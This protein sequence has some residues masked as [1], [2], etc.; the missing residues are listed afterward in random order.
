MKKDTSTII[1]L[2]LIVIAIISLI[3]FVKSNGNTDE[4]VM[5]CIAE[6]SR[7]I[8]SPTCGYCA[9]QKQDLGEY[10][11]YFEFID[12][13][14]NPEILQEYSIKGTPSWIIN[15]QVYS[16]YQTIEKLKQITGC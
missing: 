6:K 12:I 14:K 8:I 9:K 3:Y 7:I 2:I 16:G 13:S 15:E 5:K 1:I 4:K 10:I 11:D